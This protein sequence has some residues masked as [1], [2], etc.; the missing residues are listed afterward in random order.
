MSTQVTP[1]K[2]VVGQPVAPAANEDASPSSYVSGV[3]DGNLNTPMRLRDYLVGVGVVFRLSRRDRVA[4]RK[5]LLAEA[6]AIEAKKVKIP[7]RQILK[8]L[9]PIAVAAVA[10]TAYEKFSGIPLPEPVA[11]TW[12]TS[13]GKYKGRNFWI[14]PRS[15]AFQNGQSVNQFSIHS[16]TKVK[17]RR[18]A[19]TLFL[20]VDYQTDGKPAT[21]SLAYRES[22][23][24]ELRLVNQPNVRWTRQGDAPV[25]AE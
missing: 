17:G 10:W 3:A 9:A 5:E 18:V 6:A 7:V 11:G 19:D 8:I 25:I 1:E 22:P 4:E 15:V 23:S 21:L 2:P 14:N 16:I 24:P 13:D 20:S 12:A